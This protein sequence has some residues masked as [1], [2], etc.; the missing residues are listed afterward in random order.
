[1]SVFSRGRAIFGR[2]YGTIDS[3]DLFPADKKETFYMKTIQEQFII[4]AKGKKTGVILP[5]G[6]YR[7]MMEDLHD[8]AVI[9]E[10]REEKPISMAEMKKRLKKDDAL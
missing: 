5:I 6:E 7:R 3:R 2:L 9:A 10:R 8:L 1:M 4:N